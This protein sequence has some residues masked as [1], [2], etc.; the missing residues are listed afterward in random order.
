MRDRTEHTS[1]RDLEGEKTEEHARTFDLSGYYEMSLQ[2]PAVIEQESG[3]PRTRGKPWRLCS[4]W[5][6]RIVLRM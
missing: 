4:D 3:S 1:E 6:S 2:L 5:C